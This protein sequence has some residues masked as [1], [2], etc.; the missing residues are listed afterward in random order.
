MR[1]GS[2]MARSTMHGSGGVRQVL[3]RP[4]LCALRQTTHH[5]FVTRHVGNTTTWL[6]THIHGDA[7]TAPQSCTQDVQL[8][9]LLWLTCTR[10]APHPHPVIHILC[11]WLWQ[12]HLLPYPPAPVTHPKSS[13]WSSTCGCHCWRASMNSATNE[14]YS[15]PLARSRLRP[16]YLTGA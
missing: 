9:V 3:D 2:C 1:C 15:S 11:P 5:P 6:Q 7:T 10:P 4:G 8:H 13:N 12:H 14:S 16:L